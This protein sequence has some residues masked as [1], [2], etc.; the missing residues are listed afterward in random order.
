MKIYLHLIQ[1]VIPTVTEE[2]LITPIKDTNIDSLDLLAIR[3]NIEKYFGFEVSDVVWYKYQTLSQALEHFHQ[4]QNQDQ[5]NNN[6]ESRQVVSTENVEIKMPQMTNSALSENW[7][8]KYLGDNHWTLIAKGFNKKSSDIID[9]NGNRLYATFVRVTYKTSSLDK[10][11]ENDILK[12]NS[13]IEGFGRN[14]FISSVNG[15][16]NFNNIQATLLTTFSTRLQ[17]DNTEISKGNTELFPNKIHQLSKSPI[18]LT[19]YRLLKKRLLDEISTRYG[20]F[21]IVDDVIFSCEYELN[22]YYEINGVGLLYFASYPIISDKCCLKYFKAQEF[23][24]FNTIYR[25]VFY[26]ANC[27]PN[28][29]IIFQLNYESLD[30]KVLRTLTSLYRNSDK[31]LLAKIITVKQ[32]NKLS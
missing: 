3:V 15:N 32:M 13:K 24:S 8:L 27:N 30:G 18:Q 20:I 14:T 17:N 25:D 11:Q 21:P 4:N 23:L 26:F 9:Q 31:K 16:S 28:D 12:F 7:L 2:D 5:L 6:V 10:F 1:E 19:E 22:P 29:R